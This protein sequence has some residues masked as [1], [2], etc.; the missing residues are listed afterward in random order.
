M[1]L[2]ADHR[3]SQVT[4]QR[5]NV[6]QTKWLILALAVAGAT[7]AQ[8][9]ASQAPPAP[10]AT[11]LSFTEIKAAMQR[12]TGVKDGFSRYPKGAAAREIVI[13]RHGKPAGVLI[14]FE[15]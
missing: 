10:Q 14:G 13:T 12:K 6:M 5:D 1:T 9:S 7:L 4:P 15:S 11:M 3:C 8:S 2:G